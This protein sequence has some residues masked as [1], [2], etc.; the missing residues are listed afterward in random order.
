M[1]DKALVR[2][3]CPYWELFWSAF[4]RIRT[5][6]GEI[7]STRITPNT[8]TVYTV[9]WSTGSPSIPILHY[10]TVVEVRSKIGWEYVSTQ[11]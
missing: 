10:K 9:L 7:R 4:S 6:Y 1:G 2:E 5:E 11:F 3:K 8:D